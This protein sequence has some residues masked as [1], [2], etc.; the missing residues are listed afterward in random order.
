MDKKELNE[1]ITN[2]VNTSQLCDTAANKLNKDMYRKAMEGI[3]IELAVQVLDDLHRAA[4]ALEK[5][6]KFA[7][8]SAVTRYS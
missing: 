4:D 6:A 7:K 2:L 3:A 1:A 5:L 8:S